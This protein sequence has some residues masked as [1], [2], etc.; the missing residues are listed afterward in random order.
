M[1]DISGSALILNI[2]T[3]KIYLQIKSYKA[4][5]LM[6]TTQ[7]CMLF[8]SLENISCSLFKSVIDQFT[9]PYS[10]LVSSIVY[11][12]I[13]K[14]KM[15]CLRGY[16]TWKWKKISNNYERQAMY[17]Y[18]SC[19]NSYIDYWLVFLCLKIYIYIYTWIMFY[20]IYIYIHI[21]I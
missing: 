3:R 14:L 1:V 19:I 6:V 13:G 2:Y 10:R 17:M 16:C 18:S 20:F 7:R 11:N 12:R 4:R 9:N 5:N 8:S 15:L 21:N